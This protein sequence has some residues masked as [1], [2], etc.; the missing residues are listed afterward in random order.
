MILQILEV[1]DLAVNVMIKDKL[2]EKILASESLAKT[3]GGQ[4]LLE[5]AFVHGAGRDGRMM[6]VE[7]DGFRC[8]GVCVSGR[9]KN[10]F[11]ACQV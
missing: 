4:L 5:K 3:K 8:R 10:N 9:P 2:E 1:N 6:I 7:L 11:L